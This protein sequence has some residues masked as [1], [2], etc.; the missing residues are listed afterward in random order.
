MKML[1]KIPLNSNDRSRS[2][3]FNE[4]GLIKDPAIVVPCSYSFVLG[5]HFSEGRLNQ[6]RSDQYRSVRNWE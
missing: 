1:M 2:S 6:Y 3:S 5:H 4:L